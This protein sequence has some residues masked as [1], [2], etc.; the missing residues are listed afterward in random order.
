MP[1]TQEP[2]E[3]VKRPTQE[4]WYWMK[5][6]S[7][8]DMPTLIRPNGVWMSGFVLQFDELEK[9]WPTAR[10]AGPLTAPPEKTP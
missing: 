7:Y 5:R 10:F 4:G 1:N 3:Y 6:V 9:L 2:A 8:V